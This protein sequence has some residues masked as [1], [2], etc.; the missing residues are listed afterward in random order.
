MKI[1]QLKK[2]IK[3]FNETMH[4]P[5]QIYLIGIMD[6]KIAAHTRIAIVK[7]CLME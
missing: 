1:H 6:D 2:A 4:D 5:N 7:L 3:I